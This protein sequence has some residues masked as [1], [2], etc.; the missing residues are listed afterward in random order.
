MQQFSILNDEKY[1]HLKYPEG[2]FKRKSKRHDF[3][4]T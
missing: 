2:S 3:S 4:A 1:P